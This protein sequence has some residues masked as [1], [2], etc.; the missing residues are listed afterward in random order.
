ME[1]LVPI[2][3]PV[4]ESTHG[5]VMNAVGVAMDGLGLIDTATTRPI[6]SKSPDISIQVKNDSVVSTGIKV[7][8]LFAPCARGGKNGLLGAVGVGKSTMIM[9]LIRNLTIDN[10]DTHCVFAG[11]GARMR[12]ASDLYH[13]LTS[14]G[15]IDINDTAKSKVSLVLGQM[16]EPAGLRHRSALTALTVSE[17]FRDSG[18][19]VMLLIDNIYRFAQASIEVATMLGKVPFQV[20]CHPTLSSEIGDFQERISSTKKGNITSIQAIFVPDDDIDDP[21]G[22]ATLS[23]LDSAIV[24]SSN[25]AERGIYPAIDPLASL[26]RLIEPEILGERHYNISVTAKQLLQEH[27]TIKDVIN[28]LGLD[29]F[30]DEE[31]LKYKRGTKLQKFLTQPL[32]S[33]EN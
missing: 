25:K 26:S 13:Y 29:D 32:F 27:D 1:S 17:Y 12:E 19:D 6:H 14:T 33:C 15:T 5:R 3:V 31:L 11:I 2:I 20:R 21:V 10:D 4:G 30:S 16:D 23:H 7:I 9:E 22:T 24:F 8:D 18:K 28:I